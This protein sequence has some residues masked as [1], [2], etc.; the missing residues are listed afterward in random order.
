MEIY[1]YM[2]D[3]PNGEKVSLDEYKGKVLLVVN[4]ASKCGFTPQF[5]GLQELYEKYSDQGLEILGFPSDQFMNQEFSSNDE[6]MDFCK[7]NYGVSFPMFAK[8]D[9]KGESAHPLFKYLT[10]EQKGMMG[11]EVKWNFTKFLVDKEGKVVGRFAPQTKPA[12]LE[13]EIV[14]LLK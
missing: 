9:V 4:T 6:I 14:E 7:V 8:T 12:K 13:K 1:S 2:A 5:E 10:N 3:K 11:S